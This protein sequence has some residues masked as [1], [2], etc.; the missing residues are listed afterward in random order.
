MVD[1][2]NKELTTKF[3]KFTRGL[4]EIYNSLKNYHDILHIR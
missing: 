4:L 2:V 3:M 1:L